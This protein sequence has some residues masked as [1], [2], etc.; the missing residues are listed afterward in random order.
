MEA[1]YSC[2]FGLGASTDRGLYSREDDYGHCW[3]DMIWLLDIRSTKF[4]IF[5]SA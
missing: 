2:F 5:V 3:G 1:R 4:I